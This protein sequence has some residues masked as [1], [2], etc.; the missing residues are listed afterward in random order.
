MTLMDITSFKDRDSSSSF[1]KASMVLYS[2]KIG[3]TSPSKHIPYKN[4]KI[5]GHYEEGWFLGK[6]S[7]A[8]IVYCHRKRGATRNSLIL[9]S[10]TFE[11]DCPACAG[12]KAA[13][14]RDMQKQ[15]AVS[16]CE[17][18][19]LLP[20]LVTRRQNE[21]EIKKGKHQLL[22][23]YWFSMNV[24]RYRE[25]YS[26]NLERLVDSN[27]QHP[28][29]KH[30]YRIF[31]KERGETDIQEYYFNALKETD[32]HE[33]NVDHPLIDDWLDKNGNWK[34]NQDYRE[35]ISNLAL[36]RFSP[37]Q[38]DDRM[39]DYGGKYEEALKYVDE[40]LSEGWPTARIELKDGV[41][42]EEED[43]TL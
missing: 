34:W 32:A 27:E 31:A 2:L 1:S 9:C 26:A 7:D 40:L 28:I 37:Y 35:L 10:Q 5:F 13:K 36:V 15:F 19:L 23:I 12:Y 20:F 41:S 29:H 25:D 30:P 42:A 3:E 17:H 14:D 22:P 38:L 16:A 6:L 4:K 11:I 21:P 43:I 8:V 18:H 39:L 33:I 24:S